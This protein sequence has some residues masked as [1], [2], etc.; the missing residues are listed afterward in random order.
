MASVKQD[1]TLYPQILRYFNWLTSPTGS[2][3]VRQ[4]YFFALPDGRNGSIA[5]DAAHAKIYRCPLR[6]ESD[7]QLR[8]C[9]PPLLANTDTNATQR[10]DA[11]A[12]LD[13]LVRDRHQVRLSGSEHTG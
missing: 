4:S 9:G 11:V 12:T 6:L 2:D 1:S 7:S 10:G 5:T 3:A 13:I 8:K